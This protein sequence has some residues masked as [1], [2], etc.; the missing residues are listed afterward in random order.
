MGEL[1]RGLREQILKEMSYERQM[2]DEELCELI[3]GELMACAR[4]QPMPLEERLRLHKELFDSF[5]RLDVLQELVDDPQI[6]EI[7]VNGPDTVFV[8]S[9]GKIRQL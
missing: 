6:T 5:R 2:S 4:E 9:G 3:D 7:M 8:E 1:K